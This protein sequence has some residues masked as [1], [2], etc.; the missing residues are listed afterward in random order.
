MEGGVGDPR[1]L[2]ADDCSGQG[3]RGWEPVRVVAEKVVKSKQ[4]LAVLES[5][6]NEVCWMDLM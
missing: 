5:R 2:G 1:E 4:I 3:R 6:T